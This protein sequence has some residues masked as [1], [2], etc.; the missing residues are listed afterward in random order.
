MKKLLVI[1]CLFALI[2]CQSDYEKGVESFNIGYYYDAQDHFRKI[3]KLDDDYSK[4][5]MMLNK[6][7]FINDSIKKTEDSISNAKKKIQKKKEQDKKNKLLYNNIKS[8][9]KDLPEFDNNIKESSVDLVLSYYDDFDKMVIN[10]KLGLKSGVDSIV[11]LSNDFKRLYST[12]C[13]RI[14]K[15]LRF[16]YYNVVK[17]K[18]W[19]EN[20]DIVLSGSNKDHLTLIGSDFASN[21]V[22]EDTYYSI[23][24]IMLKLRFKKVSFK[25]YSYDNGVYYSPNSKKDTEF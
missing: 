13:K 6:I 5:Q 20:V 23:D 9:V 15:K 24:D 22:I 18:L 10:A 4:A 11:N 19:R 21:A 1:G 17:D 3:H 12:Y 8:Y 14:F 25:W 7:Y 2:G 16:S